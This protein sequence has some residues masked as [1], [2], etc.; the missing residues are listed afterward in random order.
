MGRR[1]PRIYGIPHAKV[2][3]ELFWKSSGVAGYRRDDLL[4]ECGKCLTLDDAAL[5]L[6]LASET[7][8]QIAR[9]CSTS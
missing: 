2:T 8:R 9:R 6:I 1:R 7:S 4:E 5:I 3:S